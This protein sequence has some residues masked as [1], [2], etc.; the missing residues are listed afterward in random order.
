[1]TNG[2]KRIEPSIAPSLEA[3][4]VNLL[5]IPILQKR[6]T[7]VRRTW[8]RAKKSA[9]SRT[10]G[11]LLQPCN[12]GKGRC[13]FPESH[14]PIRCG[15]SPCGETMPSNQ[16]SFYRQMLSGW[17]HLWT[18]EE[19]AWNERRKAPNPFGG[20]QDTQR[21]RDIDSPSMPASRPF[22]EPGPEDGPLI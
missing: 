20:A 13:I 19:I 2:I 12:R 9:T 7:S 21:S 5:H 15:M 14:E 10:R 6:L 1:M 16:L 3:L 22:C 8:R 17:Y 11:K 18:H 4:D